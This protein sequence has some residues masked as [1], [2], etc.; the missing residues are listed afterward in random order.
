[1][2]EFSEAP[3]DAQ[4]SQ[5]FQ[6]IR[7]GDVTLAH[8]VVLAPLTRL[9]ANTRGVHGDL[10]V[11]YYAQRGSVPGSLLI[12][13]ATCISRQ[14]EGRSP[15]APG[16]WNE[17]QIAAW[18]RVSA[19]VLREDAYRAKLGAVSHYCG[20]CRLLTRSTPRGRSYTCKYGHSV[21]QLG[22]A[23]FAS[24][25]PTLLTFPRRTS[26]FLGGMRPQDL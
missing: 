12:S 17:E 13:E 23:T 15:N 14:A 11:E 25:I 24:G 18:K 9:R 26:H 5:L 2:S 3:T 21:A 22:L 20:Y 10:A 19:S 1:M 6:P 16:I 4:S 7:V 8:R